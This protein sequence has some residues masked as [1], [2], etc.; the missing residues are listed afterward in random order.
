MLNELV[1]Y[2]ERC[3]KIYNMFVCKFYYGN[4]SYNL[5][6]RKL[7]R[8]LIDTQLTFCLI[9]VILKVDTSLKIR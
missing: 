9:L 5:K 3:L 4:N 2:I 6:D 1:C 8:W 7:K